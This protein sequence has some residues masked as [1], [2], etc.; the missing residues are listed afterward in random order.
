MKNKK[1]FVF[2]I[3]LSILLVLPSMV[4]AD[5]EELISQ[6]VS[7]LLYANRFIVSPEDNIPSVA[8]THDQND[9]RKITIVAKSKNDTIEQIKYAKKM[10]KEELIDFLNSLYDFTMYKMI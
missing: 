3:T 9:S 1:L 5:D 8:I 7:G 10:V 4:R 6:I 2:I